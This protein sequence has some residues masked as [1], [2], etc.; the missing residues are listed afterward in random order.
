MRTMS[1]IQMTWA[2]KRNYDDTLHSGPDTRG[3]FAGW[4]ADE[5][6]LSGEFATAK[7]KLID[8]QA[9]RETAHPLVQERYLEVVNESE[10]KPHSLL[11]Y[12][13]IIDAT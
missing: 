13:C 11:V 10:R 7:Q 6:D 5:R 9:L 3:T 12:C 1:E 4:F 2:A 8:E